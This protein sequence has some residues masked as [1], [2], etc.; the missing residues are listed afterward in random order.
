MK[1][2]DRAALELANTIVPLYEAKKSP[3]DVQ[4]CETILPEGMKPK[5]K[6]HALYL[7][8]A[9]IG[10]F[11][12]DAEIFYGSTRKFYKTNSQYF[13][14][15]I[16]IEEFN[17]EADD[18]SEIIRIVNE[19]KVTVS[20]ELIS[21]VKENLGGRWWEIGKRW[22]N[23]SIELEKYDNDP[24]N[25]FEEDDTI[26]SVFKKL[27][28]KRHPKTKI[29]NGFRGMKQKIGNM[30]INQYIDAGIAKV[31]DPENA[32]VPIDYHVIN[33]TIARGILTDFENGI[34]DAK[35][36]DYLEKE[37]PR[38]YKEYDISALNFGKAIWQLGKYSCSYNNSN[39]ACPIEK[40]EKIIDS[41]T[42]FTSGKIVII[43]NPRGC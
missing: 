21:V 36:T 5:S 42:Y 32:K 10:N 39:D 11:A 26:D 41:S 37:Y 14:P 6:E 19:E 12:V 30:F 18:F 29:Q 23:N 3:F 2:N 33:L 17:E 8:Y 43:D 16:I 38:F 1:F 22:W 9:A 13:K 20:P 35:I 34:R 40:C 15:Q 4:S 31:K 27:D 24:R 25:I 7:F 28:G